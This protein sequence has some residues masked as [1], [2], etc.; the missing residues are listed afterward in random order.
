MGDAVSC[1]TQV[2]DAVAQSRG[3]LKILF[4]MRVSDE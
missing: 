1:V 3:Q 4:S 2:G